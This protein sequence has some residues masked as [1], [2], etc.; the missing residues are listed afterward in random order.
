MGRLILASFLA[1]VAIILVAVGLYPLPGHTRYASSIAVVPNGGRLEEFV[2][3]WPQ[4]RIDFP[5]TLNGSADS[6][7]SGTAILTDRDASPASG[8]LFRLSDVDG[9]VIGIA[10]KTTV[11]VRG[12]GDE[13]Q[14]VSNWMLMIPSRGTLFLNQINRTDLAPR[15]MPQSP[16]HFIAAAES[17]DFWLDR[18]SYRATAGPAADSMGKV[19]RGTNE[20][21]A[22]SGSYSEQWELD[23]KRADGTAEGRITLST[24]LEIIQ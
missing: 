13:A 15:M 8:E 4:D 17:A 9:N 14:S 6:A 2:I 11:T 22:L 24:V 1:G 16:R 10:S 12:D 21:A 23:G 18:T 20:F 3:R 19:L 7:T 5:A